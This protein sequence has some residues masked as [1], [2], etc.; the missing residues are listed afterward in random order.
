MGRS[1]PPGSDQ[2][3]A[4]HAH[5]YLSWASL[6]RAGVSRIVDLCSLHYYSY[7]GKHGQILVSRLLPSS[8]VA[9]RLLP[10]AGSLFPVHDTPNK[11]KL[12]LLYTVIHLSDCQ[13]RETRQ[14]WNQIVANYLIS[15]LRTSLLLEDLLLGELH[16][17][18]VRGSFRLRIRIRA[19][20][21]PISR[22]IVT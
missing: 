20:H 6:R 10:R 1:R 17:G 3:H 19:G 7:C 22:V 2:P 13:T 9:R 11:A 16:S 14:L 8:D 18:H 4:T 12:P 21:M 5:L 15:Q